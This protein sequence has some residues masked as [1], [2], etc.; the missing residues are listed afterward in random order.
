VLARRVS[1]LVHH[2]VEPLQLAAILVERELERLSDQELAQ[3]LA[4]RDRT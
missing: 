3:G 1:G 2:R 4:G